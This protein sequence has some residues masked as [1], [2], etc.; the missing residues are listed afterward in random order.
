MTLMAVRLPKLWPRCAPPQERWP[1]VDVFYEESH[2]WHA[3]RL[4]RR[5]SLRRRT[6]LRST[7]KVMT[8]PSRLAREAVLE[9]DGFCC[10]ACGFG[11]GLQP[12]HRVP[13]GRGG[14][15]DPQ[16]HVV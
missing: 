8:G 10:V 9:R 13:V 5:K 6:P 12:H 15:S 4:V 16:V 11:G 2:R 3:R 1:D 14:S 7:R